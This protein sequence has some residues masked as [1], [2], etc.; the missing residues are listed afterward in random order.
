M[1]AITFNGNHGH[2]LMVLKNSYLVAKVT[3]AT[4]ADAL[5]TSLLREW[6]GIHRMEDDLLQ[7]FLSGMTEPAGLSPSLWSFA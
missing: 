1:I 6:K 3:F 2:K 5:P 7:V 4:S